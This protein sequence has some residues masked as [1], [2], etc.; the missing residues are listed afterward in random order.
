M[1][2]LIKSAWRSDESPKAAF[3]FLHA[4]AFWRR[5]TRYRSSYSA[6]Q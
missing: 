5:G 2:V 3:A 6:R 1:K 4:D